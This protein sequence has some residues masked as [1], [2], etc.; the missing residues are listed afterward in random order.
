VTLSNGDRTVTTA[1]TNAYKYVLG[2][3][4]V[5]AG[6]HVWYV[7]RE[8]KDQ[9]VLVVNNNQV[10]T[11]RRFR[12]TA[13]SSNA[14]LLFA[15]AAPGA[16][17]DTSYSDSSCYGIAGSSALWAKGSASA[18]PAASHTSVDGYLWSQGD[19]VELT[20]NCEARTLRI[21]S[22]LVDH[23]IPDLPAGQTWVPMV[24]IVSANTSIQIMP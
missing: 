21:K 10:K 7:R 14:W 24:N 4:G 13:L 6:V 15:V 23:T 8:M 17:S 1:G 5:S 9:S 11:D 22:R 20:L 19:V 2:K 12:V 18:L 16:K 3:A